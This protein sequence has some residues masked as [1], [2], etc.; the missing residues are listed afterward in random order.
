MAQIQHI[1]FATDYSEGSARACDMTRFLL[2]TTG[3]RLTV[4]HVIAELVDPHRRL[5]PH[6][7]ANTFAQEVERCAVHDM[8]AFCQA[9]FPGITVTTEI[10]I[11]RPHEQINL[12]AKANDVD[13]IVMG[14]H[15]RTGLEKLFVGSTAEKVVRTAS[16]PV[17]TIRE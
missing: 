6:T 13:L 17:M 5:L 16:V 11:G 2:H 12:F 7:L 10:V 1:V 14:T 4:L 3:A 9:H 15:G 8:N